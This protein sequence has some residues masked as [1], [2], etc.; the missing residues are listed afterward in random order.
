MLDFR[1]SG[2]WKIFVLSKSVGD[3]ARKYFFVSKRVQDIRLKLAPPIN[4]DG[5]HPKE[6][7]GW[8][9]IGREQTTRVDQTSPTPTTTTTTLTV[10]GPDGFAAGKK[11]QG[12]E[13][14]D[15]LLGEED[16]LYSSP[17]LSLYRA[18][19]VLEWNPPTKKCNKLITNGIKIKNRNFIDIP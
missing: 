1:L 19:K 2:G 18:P 11:R 14:S 10:I 7:Y 12:G 17:S 4:L 3:P 13:I 5:S 6:N 9:I 16:S 8:E 15:W